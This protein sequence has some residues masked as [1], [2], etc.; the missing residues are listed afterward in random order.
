MD[1]DAVLDRL[2]KVRG[3]GGDKWAACCPAHEDGSPSLSIRLSS[4][5]NILVYCFAGCHV[6]DIC[7]AIGL[8][9]KD[10]FHEKNEPRGTP[11]PRDTFRDLKPHIE[12]TAEKAAAK[13][14]AWLEAQGVKL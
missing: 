12:A 7:A 5:G 10:L 13:N 2:E 4:S 6:V 1:I 3:H 9:Q 14:K 8:E 11:R